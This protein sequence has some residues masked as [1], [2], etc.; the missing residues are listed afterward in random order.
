MS[1][2]TTAPRTGPESEDSDDDVVRP[3]YARP[4]ASPGPMRSIGM[5]AEKS[6]DF[7]GTTKRL[8]GRMREERMRVVAVVALA[9]LSVTSARRS[10]GMRPT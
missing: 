4:T 1:T 6:K 3:D 8:L 2:D 5:P 9:V 10:S 7:G